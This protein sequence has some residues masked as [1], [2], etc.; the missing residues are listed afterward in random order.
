[1]L[2]QRL[3][4]T[5]KNLDHLLNVTKAF[6]LLTSRPSS[7]S[8]PL[9]EKRK[10]G[11]RFKV[12]SAYSL[13]WWLAG[14]EPCGRTGGMAMSGIEFISKSNE[15]AHSYTGRMSLCRSWDF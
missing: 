15:A 6:A 12:G 10:S 11:L 13:A 2:C 7:W 14:E 3:Q 1:V 4:L 5:I 9:S 8:T